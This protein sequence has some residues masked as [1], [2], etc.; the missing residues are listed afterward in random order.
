MKINQ[1]YLNDGINFIEF[2]KP[3]EFSNLTLPKY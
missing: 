1:K 3:L 2:P